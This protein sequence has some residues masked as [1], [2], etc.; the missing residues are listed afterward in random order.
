MWG[1]YYAVKTWPNFISHFY[2]FLSKLHNFKGRASACKTNGTS[3]RYK[4]YVVFVGTIDGKALT[5]VKDCCVIEYMAE[6]EAAA[7]VIQLDGRI[8]R[9]KPLRAYSVLLGEARRFI[10]AG[11]S[12]SQR[13]PGAAAAVQVAPAHGDGVAAAAAAVVAAASPS[14][15]AATA[16][17]PGGAVRGAAAGGPRG[18]VPMGDFPRGGAPRADPRGPHGAGAISLGSAAAARLAESWPLRGSPM[19]PSGGPPRAA[20]GR[21][22]P[23]SPARG[24]PA[25]GGGPCTYEQRQNGSSPHAPPRGGVPPPPPFRLPNPAAGG[26]REVRRVVRGIQPGK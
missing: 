25:P 3:V 18:N 1:S 10:Q 6:A 2:L 20:Y 14:L 11:G 22:S 7:A 24:G 23:L 13:Q 4:Q 8:W 15:G 5:A 26:E 16:R 17:A 21:G 9:N 19:G 12:L